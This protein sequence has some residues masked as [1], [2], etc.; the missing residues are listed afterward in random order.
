MFFLCDWE[1]GRILW[2]STNILFFTV[3]LAT[4]TGSFLQ[5]FLLWCLPKGNFQFPSLLLCL[6]IGILQSNQLFPFFCIYLLIQL[7]IYIRMYSWIFYGLRFITIII[8]YL[9]CYSDCPTLTLGNSLKLALLYFFHVPINLWALPHCH[10]RMNY[11]VFAVKNWVND[12]RFSTA[13]KQENRF[14]SQSSWP[15]LALILYSSFWKFCFP[16]Y[17]KIF[18]LPENSE[19]VLDTRQTPDT[20]NWYLWKVV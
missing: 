5:P 8:L 15:L 17:S 13:Q 1:H 3:I 14:F 9:F 2:D 18:H 6:L 10:H 12:L 4:I 7:F 19:E 16:S 20:E 11:T